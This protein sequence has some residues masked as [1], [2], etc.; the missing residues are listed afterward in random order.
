MNR[1]RFI[2]SATAAAAVSLRVAA[3]VAPTV[4]GSRED[5]RGA[6]SVFVDTSEDS[7][8]HDAVVAELK[9]QLPTLA[10]REEADGADLVVRCTRGVADERQRNADA[11]RPPFDAS[12]GSQSPAEATIPRPSRPGSR[13]E[14]RSGSDSWNDHDA[15]A[16][17][18]RF[19]LGSVLKRVAGGP[20]REAVAFRTPVHGQAESAVRDF[21]RKLAKELE[22]ANRG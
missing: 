8:L 1:R 14:S 11:I 20:A 16:D 7:A 9:A 4:R 6:K 5:L 10:I 15:T 21:V 17:T 22:K 12:E 2:L 19:L 18:S 13:E 3:Q